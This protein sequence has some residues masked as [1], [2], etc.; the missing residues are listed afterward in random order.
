MAEDRRMRKYSEDRDSAVYDAIH[1][2]LNT[3]PKQLK[4]FVGESIRPPAASG[5]YQAL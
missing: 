2:T 5:A 4:E 3:P 1:R